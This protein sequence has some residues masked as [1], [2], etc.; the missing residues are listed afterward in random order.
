[1]AKEKSGVKK[2]FA[3]AGPVPAMGTAEVCQVFSDEGWEIVSTV[4]VG[5]V[6]VN[7]SDS[8]IVQVNGMPKLVPMVGIVVSKNGMKDKPPE[9]PA[10]KEFKFN[11]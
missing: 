1:M 5:A 3:I 10:V 9:V 7:G 2:W 8:K 11:V 6:P 4:P